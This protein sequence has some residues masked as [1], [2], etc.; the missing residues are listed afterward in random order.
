MWW[1]ASTLAW[2][3]KVTLTWN[4]VIRFGFNGISSTFLEKRKLLEASSHPISLVGTLCVFHLPVFRHLQFLLTI[5]Q[6]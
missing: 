3:E 5:V 1:R 2:R 4:C 6:F